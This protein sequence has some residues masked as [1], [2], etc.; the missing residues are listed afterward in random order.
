MASKYIQKYPIPGAFPE[1]LHDFAREILRDQPDNIYEYG[2]AY[3]TALDN[4]EEFSY[5][6]VGRN[7]PPPRDRE[8]SM[9]NVKQMP[10][11]VMSTEEQ[12]RSQ[13]MQPTGGRGVGAE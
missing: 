2:A 5:D 13:S 4:G 1:L 8:P 11:G 9:G 10:E 6:K 12:E 3:F 7:V